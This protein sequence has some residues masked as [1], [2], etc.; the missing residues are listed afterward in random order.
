MEEIAP[1]MHCNI[2]L[3]VK[4]KRNVCVILLTTLLTG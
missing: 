1:K 4:G 3:G 2:M